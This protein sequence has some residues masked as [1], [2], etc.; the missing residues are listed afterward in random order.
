M[1]GCVLGCCRSQDSLTRLSSWFV[2]TLWHST[3]VGYLISN[4]VIYIYIVRERVIHR[5]TVLLYHNS[6]AWLDTRDAS[7]WN[8]NPAGFFC[9]SNILPLRSRH[10]SVNEGILRYILIYAYRLLEY[11]LHV[12]S[13]AF[14]SLWHGPFPIRVLN[15]RGGGISI[16][17]STD[18]LLCCI[19]T[20]QCGQ[21]LKMLQAG[22]ENRVI[23]RQSDILPLH[24]RYL[25]VSEGILL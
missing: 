23:F 19:T 8:R 16:L 22:I 25:S 15:T 17:S 18:R 7:S 14:T 12:K 10:L 6:P 4:P 24:S 21:T 1:N 13:F 20:L 11:S 2:C 9:L 5:K 3:L